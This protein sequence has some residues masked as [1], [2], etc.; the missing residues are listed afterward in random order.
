MFDLSE[1]KILITGAS[2]GIGKDLSKSFLENGADV[3]ITGTSSEKL[4]LLNKDLNSRCKIFESDLSSICGTNNLIDFINGLGG[5]DILVNNAGKTEDNLFLRMTDEQ[6]EDIMMINLTSVMR[7]TRGIVRGMIKK[8]W[9]RIINISSIVAL[10]GNPGQSNYVAAKSGLIGFS[11]S[12]AS[13]VAS[14]GITVNCIAPGFVETNMTNKL[15]E[16]Q[17]NL[18][19]SRI[20]MKRIGLP[21]EICSSAIF[22]ASSYSSYI[23]GQTIHINGGMYMS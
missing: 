4:K 20:P 14:R 8:R 2:G 3:I 7:L 9:G 22:L 11:K 17:K 15:N 1:K 23:T 18:I 13:E 21:I 5:V 12:L 16:N 19:L 10:T 6:W